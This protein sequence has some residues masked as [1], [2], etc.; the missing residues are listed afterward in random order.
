MDAFS[1]VSSKNKPFWIFD[2]S[3]PSEEEAQ[4]SSCSYMV[5]S[6]NQASHLIACRWQVAFV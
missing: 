3:V 2:T 5:S 4:D 6:R 1:L